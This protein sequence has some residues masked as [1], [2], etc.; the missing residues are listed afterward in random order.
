MFLP[1]VEHHNFVL[2]QNESSAHV[3]FTGFLQQH[4]SRNHCVA[5]LPRLDGALSE[6]CL[7]Y[8]RDA[9]LLS[10][11]IFSWQLTPRVH[12]CTIQTG[13]EEICHL[14]WQPLSRH[15]VACTGGGHNAGCVLQPYP[16][17][18]HPAHNFGLC[19]RCWS[20]GVITECCFLFAARTYY[21]IKI[22]VSTQ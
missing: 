4:P 18:V 10:F 5:L 15:Y 7:Q 1:F 6:C 19:C 12:D 3:I 20:V 21:C 2:V 8:L 16:H 11:M 13:R 17:G 14:C 22:T 9:C